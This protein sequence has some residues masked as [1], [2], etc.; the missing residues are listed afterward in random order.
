MATTKSQN[1]WGGKGP[2]WTVKS[3][4]PA[5][6]KGSYKL[7]M[8]VSS[9][10][11]NTSNEEDLSQ[12][13][14]P[15]FNHPT[16]EKCFLLF[17]QNFPCF[18]FCLLPFLSLGSTEKTH[19]VFSAPPTRY[20]W[21]LLKFLWALSSWSWTIL[22]LSVSSCMRDAPCLWT[23][24]NTEINDDLNIKPMFK[25]LLNEEPRL[26]KYMQLF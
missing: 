24:N 26:A 21:T 23:I 7:P 10:A 18:S 14:A 5:Q 1:S 19:S 8:A 2:P 4:P 12:R 9:Q 15:V 3:N 17:R 6:S 13:L 11:S 25:Y 22:P 16:V 20:L